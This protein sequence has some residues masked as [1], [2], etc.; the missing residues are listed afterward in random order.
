M[1][2]QIDGRKKMEILIDD[3]NAGCDVVKRFYTIDDGEKYFAWAT[4]G[5]SRVTLD[6]SKCM[7]RCTHD[8]GDESI[9]IAPGPNAIVIYD[10][11]TEQ[12]EF[13]FVEGMLIP[14]DR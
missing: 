11:G 1:G 6:P 12:R 7:F 2:L 13:I 10:N 9:Y 3:G 4:D 5:C 14:R 8:R